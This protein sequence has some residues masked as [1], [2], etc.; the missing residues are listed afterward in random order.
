MGAVAGAL[1]FAV[2]PEFMRTYEEYR[3]LFFSIVLM[4]V[5]LVAPEGIWGLITHAYRLVTKRRSY[6]EGA[7]G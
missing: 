2:V 4:A 3:L 1:L 7:L 5:V 6:R